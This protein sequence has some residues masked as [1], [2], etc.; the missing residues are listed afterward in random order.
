MTLIESALRAQRVLL[1]L[2]N[3]E[4]VLDEAA[5]AAQAL[6]RALPR[7]QLLAS[8]RQ[9]LGIEGE[10]LYRVPSLTLPGPAESPTPADVIASEAA[11]LFVDRAIA[12][13]PGFALTARNAAAIA[14]VCRQLDGIPLAIELAAARLTALSVEEIARR[15]DDRFRLLTGGLRTALP[16]QR[17]LRALVDWSY[18]LLAPDERSVLNAL[19]VFAGSFSLEGAE[20]VAVDGV[21][22]GTQPLDVIEML[23]A[24]SLLIAETQQG[25]GTRYRL[26]ETIKQYAAEKLAESGLADTVRARHFSYFVGLAETGA[27]ALAG[28]MA[29]EWLDRLDAEHDNLRAALDGSSTDALNYA[30]LA[31]A[32][33]T[34]WDTRGHFTEG[35]ARLERALA[36]HAARDAVRLDALIGAGVIVYRLGDTQRSDDILGEAMTLA[37]ELGN[38]RGE[39]EATLWCAYNRSPLGAD[40]V[41][42]LILRGQALAIA[43][44]DRSREAL[45]LLRLGRIA[46]ERGQRAKAQSLF[47]ESARV[48]ADAGFV[49]EA[50]AAI[51]YAGEC[52][53]EQLDFPAAQRLPDDAL[54]QHRR[55]GNLHD[56]ARR[57]ACWRGWRSASSGWTRHARCRPR[58]CA[59]S[60]HC[61][62]RSAARARPSSMP[63]CWMHAVTRPKRCPMP[64]PPSRPIANSAFLSRWRGRS[65]PWD[66]SMPGWARAMLRGARCSTGS[67]SSSGPTAIPHCPNCSRRSQPCIRTR[68]S[69]RSS[70]AP[71]RPCESR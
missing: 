20:S 68:P 32:L 55:V 59:S 57:W 47:L 44:G 31:G 23:V 61:T 63:T 64:S 40:A 56:A 17:T 14:R 49:I 50:P 4:H 1:L 48:F 52:A 2:D 9:A 67:S 35:W 21:R 60:A 58:A 10:T 45:A 46:M 19:A 71:R 29:L 51:Q 39:A 30:R 43:A 13:Q 8:S 37:R 42:P 36:V 25:A 16:R 18:D 66:A 62:I 65:A 6:L 38:V 12:V 34:F 33:R 26:L 22:A 24:K 53:L 28:P 54:V 70:W 41:E 27:K 3:C 69:P 5:K 7:L 11:Q 15:I